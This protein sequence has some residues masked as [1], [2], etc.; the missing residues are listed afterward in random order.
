MEFGLILKAVTKELNAFVLLNQRKATV[1]L[2]RTCVEDYRNLP[3]SGIHKGRVV[4]K[5]WRVPQSL[6]LGISSNPISTCSLFPSSV[7]TSTETGFL[8]RRSRKR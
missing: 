7:L 5:A 4:L 3:I 8:S 1:W 2:E 6:P